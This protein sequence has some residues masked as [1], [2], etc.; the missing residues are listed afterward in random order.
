M[1]IPLNIPWID[2]RELDKYARSLNGYLRELEI[3]GKN[4]CITDPSATCLDQKA[5]IQSGPLINSIRQN[6]KR[7]EEY[8]KFPM[9]IQKYI[10]WKERYIAQI[11]CNIN[12]IQQ[13]T[14][15]WLRNN[16]LRF[17]KWAELFVLIKGI[18]DSWQPLLDIFADTSA[19]C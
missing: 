5:K 11:L 15:G 12:T 4:F 1:N 10:T 16:G 13:I 9:K 8:K 19:S 6:L 18:A 7:I 17:R 3:A 14:S 2:K